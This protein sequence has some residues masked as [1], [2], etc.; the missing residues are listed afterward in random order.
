MKH[1]I[2]ALRLARRELNRGLS[3]FRIFL[4]CLILGVATIAG[5][6]SLSEALLEGLS[7]Q[8]RN[9][10]GGDIEVRMNQREVAKK[11]LEWLKKNGAIS[12]VA[13]L[14]AMAIA[15]GRDAR[16]L[17]ELKAV[18]HAYPLYGFADVSPRE[19]LGEVFANRAGVF[20]AAIDERLLA[21][22]GVPQGSVVKIGSAL[23]ELRTVIRQEP[24]RVAGGFSL[25]P[26]VMISE[27]ALR[28]TGLV[29]P[30]SL[31][32]FNYRVALPPQQASRQAV[33]QWIDKAKK[34]FPDVGWQIRDRWNAAPGVRRFIEQVGAF[35]TLVGLTALV[36]GGV[37]I[38][39]AV[40][41]Y[42]DR[43]R[44]DIATLKCVG[45]SGRFIFFMFL[46]EVMALAVIGVGIGLLLGAFLPLVAQWALNSVL[47]FKAEFSLYWR[48]VVSA[49]GFGLV[50]ALAFAIWP[51]ARAKEVSPAV[52][53]RDLV[54]P[55]RHWPQPAY[56]VATI[57][58]FG[59]LASLALV[60]T[61]N[62]QL[63]AGFAVG[64]AIAFL[65][66]RVT[67][68][69]LMWVARNVPRPKF[70]M[71]RL[72]LSNIYRPGA[73]TPAVI[74]SLG[75]G[76]TLLAAIA[77]VDTNIR[78]VM[79]DEIPAE[80]PSFFFVDVQS[81]QVKPFEQLVK[82]IKGVSQ[83]EMVPMIRGRIVKLK[84]VPADKAVVAREA[85]WALNGDRGITY[86]NPTG[87]RD[88]VVAGKWWPADYKESEGLVSFAEDLAKG[89]GLK[90]GDM[91]TVNVLGVEI[92]LKIANLR[93]VDFSNARMNFIMVVS[94]GKLERAPHA[95][96]ATAR[97][98]REKEDE[99]ERAVTN[100][101]PNVSVVRVRE[102]L[103][104]ANDLLQQ[105]A[106]GIRSA[107]F[108]TLLTGLLVLAGAL[109]AGHRHR[110]FDAVVLKVLG[111]TKGQVMTTYLMEFA[112]L[113][114]GAGFVA[115]ILGTIAAAAVSIWVM[116]TTFVPSMPTLFAVVAGGAIAAMALGIASTWTALSTPAARTLR[117]A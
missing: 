59:L 2:L 94:P 84:D 78:R 18:D 55:T 20:G 82:G 7:K 29:Q 111:A 8:G 56:I 48:P 63:A 54:S 92:P 51:L 83:F 70:M 73:P 57:L 41:A 45:A 93:R 107:S 96:L 19:P 109:A 40:T 69:G 77:L 4:A 53:F 89:M 67:G 68:W 106:G 37:G 27:F 97:V 11:E 65:L 14:R 38:G 62:V 74:L 117:N 12:M 88:Q 103:E 105:L 13:E 43:R 98:T 50:T 31:I 58:A 80:A 114:A 22:L 26:R 16:A 30:G 49:A 115:A 32:N 1:A 47:P 113:G 3:G 110:L 71:A 5:V 6:G 25:G 95:Y 64:A 10:L 99:V 75:L 102:T 116:E 36:V 42:L 15:Q 76:L 87:A 33:T 90:V 66:L 34:E 17:V 104:T 46:A 85:K 44:D 52:M 81:D 35:L 28:A 112:V 61:P 21:K 91:I 100:K 86:G 9:L 72:A 108:V 101:F 39:S 79:N 24:D 60:L 23:F